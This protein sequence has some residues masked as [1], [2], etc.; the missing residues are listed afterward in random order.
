[1]S[2]NS[3][4]RHNF[5]LLQ[6]AIQDGNVVLLECT[7]QTTGLPVMT[8]CAMQPSKHAGYEIEWVPLA[9]LFDGNPYEE[10]SPPAETDLVKE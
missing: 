10:L 9:K 3:A 8:V 7:D 2:I 6:K 5:S 4:Y 1:M